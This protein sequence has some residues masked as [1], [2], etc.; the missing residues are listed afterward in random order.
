VSVVNTTE[1]CRFEVR[2]PTP[3]KAVRQTGIVGEVLCPVLVG[4]VRRSKL[5]D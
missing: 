3:A 5:P 2:L 4:G 1:G